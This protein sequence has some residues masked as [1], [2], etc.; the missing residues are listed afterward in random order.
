MVS[1]NQAF[2]FWNTLSELEQ[3]EV[4]NH[5]II[6]QYDAGQHLEKQPGLYLVSDGSIVL[7][8]EHETG[9]RR[10]SFSAH[11]M[12]FM[13]LTP[14]FLKQCEA[15]SVELYAREST[16]ICFIRFADWNMLAKKN[17]EIGSFS[18][19]LLSEQLGR[20]AFAVY[21]RMEKDLSRRLALF[22][23]MYYERDKKNMGNTI[24]V[25]HEELAEQIGTGREA[26]TRN[27]NMLKDAG[28]V[29]TGRGKIRILNLEALRTYVNW[30]SNTDGEA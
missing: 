29:Q 26:V 24:L 1:L 25:S 17:A 12:E 30:Q 14:S 28:L 27:I 6:R 7:Y 4:R 3:E 11:W 16:E 9:R 22:L 5:I 23:I 15:I 20:Q 18:V 13:L 8:S 19:E 10:V 21:A 2:P